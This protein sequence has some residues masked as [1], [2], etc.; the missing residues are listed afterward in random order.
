[1]LGGLPG[2]GMAIANLVRMAPLLADRQGACSVANLYKVTALGLNGRTA[3]SRPP[4]SMRRWCR[5]VEMGRRV[6]AAVKR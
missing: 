1:M 2:A 3:C 4:R 6:Q 5:L